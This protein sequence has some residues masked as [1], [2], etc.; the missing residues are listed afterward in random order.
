MYKVVQ[1]K[2]KS[3]NGYYMIQNQEFPEQK[4]TGD[5]LACP[6]LAIS[7]KRDKGVRQRRN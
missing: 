7:S 6:F 2:R 1:F 3:D 4:S 5:E